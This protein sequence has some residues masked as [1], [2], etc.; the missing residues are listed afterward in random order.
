MKLNKEQL[1]QYAKKIWENGSSYHSYIDQQLDILFNK[2]VSEFNEVKYSPKPIF[3]VVEWMSSNI[4]NNI[5]NQ[6]WFRAGNVRKILTN[7]NKL[8]RFNEELTKFVKFGL[9]FGSF[10]IV[11]Y[12]F[13]PSIKTISLTKDE[14]KAFKSK[15]ADDIIDVKQFDDIYVVSYRVVY[16]NAKFEWINPKNIAFDSAMKTFIRRVHLTY[17]ELKSIGQHRRIDDYDQI[18]IGVETFYIAYEIYNDGYLYIA[19]SK[20]EIV[21]KYKLPVKMPIF[22]FAPF[23]SGDKLGYGLTE[24]GKDSQYFQTIFDRSALNNVKE[25]GD[26]K[27][28]YDPRSISKK[29]IESNEKYLQ[30]KSPEVDPNNALTPVKKNIPLLNMYVNI[31]EYLSYK[32]ENQTGFTRYSQGLSAKSLN[33]TATGISIIS[34]MSQQRVIEILNRLFSVLE[35]ILFTQYR[36]LKYA[37]VIKTNVDK[38][39][40]IA[41]NFDVFKEKQ[42]EQLLKFLQIVGQFGE[43]AVKTLNIEAIIHKI[44]KLLNLDQ[45][46]I[47]I[48]NEPFNLNNLTNGG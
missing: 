13:T 4:L 26:I 47:F 31:N 41:E 32:F 2:E 19:N 46:V 37:G 9:A 30:L 8:T 44:A 24:L 48:N 5:I 33:K 42:L 15:R 40:V 12:V 3:S 29:D 36:Y 38:I 18:E 10:G 35:E 1:Q 14:Y 11:R 6:N 25:S 22:Y 28:I 20:F 21:K 27:F 23:V 34:N 45:D 7:N 16:K 39:E 17:D 43:Q